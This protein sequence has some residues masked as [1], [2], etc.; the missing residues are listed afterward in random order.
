MP[1]SFDELLRSE[2]EH[3]ER[4]YFAFDKMRTEARESVHA[5][6]DYVRS[7]AYE[8]Q[9]AFMA[10]GDMSA[11]RNKRHKVEN[12]V[13]KLYR[14]PYFAH[15]ELREEEYGDI[16]HFYLSDSESLDEVVHIGRYGS[17]IPFKQDKDRPISMA[18]FHLYQSKNGDAMHY[19]GNDGSMIGFSPLLICDDEIE[20]RELLNV[21]QLFPEQELL[22]VNADE[23]LEQKLLENR[24]DP[25]LKNII[26][27]LQ[28]KQFQIIE[29]DVHI[30]FI[31]QGCAGSGKSQ[32]LLHRLFFLRDVLSQDGRDKVLLLT[33]TQ[34]FRNYSAELIKRYQ[35]S[36]IANCSISE[37]YQTLLNRYDNRF[38]NRQYQFELTEEYLPDAYLHVVYSED[39]LQLIEREI[40]KAIQSY[41]K[42]AC[43]ALGETLSTYIDAVYITSLITKLDKEIALFDERELVL[44]Q[45]PDYIDHRNRYEEVQKELESLQRVADRWTKE[46]E[47]LTQDEEKLS[48]AVLNFQ[49]VKKEVAQWKSQ[50]EKRIASAF[51]AVARFDKLLESD[52]RYEAPAR[53]MKNLYSL[54][55]LTTG[56]TYRDDEEYLQF[57]NEYYEQAEKELLELTK[58]QTP[59]RLS[60]RY[61]KRKEDIRH[62]LTDISVSIESLSLELA[63]NEEWLREKAAE[64][65]G[66]K[67]TRTLR[68]ADMERARYFLARIES[69]VFEREVWNAL[70][71]IKEEN[72]IQT[73]IIEEKKD[74][75]HH[76]TRILYKSDLL[77]YIKI[78]MRLLPNADLPEYSLLCID[79]GQDLHKADYDVLHQLYPNAV[80]NIFGDTEQV[81]HEDCG[82]S[83]W[84]GETGVKKMFNLETNYRN[85][86]GIV[87]FCNRRFGCEMKYLGKAQEN[88][89]PVV[90]QNLSSIKN[91][92]QDEN[93]VVILKDRK[94]FEMFVDIINYENRCEFLDT[95]A[96]STDGEKISCYSIF[97]AKG[98]EFSRV[99]VFASEMTINQRIVA[100]TRATEKLYYYE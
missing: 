7:G 64:F 49:D 36:D 10:Y 98:L 27:T 20:N 66:E 18:L 60:K 71:P 88:Q 46:L 92:L 21:M 13:Q 25:R 84:Q 8:D 87:E 56:D 74:G 61:A 32:C 33:P 77:F 97:A 34:L 96:A 9:D 23:L 38:R 43:E 54:K 19:R 79:E 45:D 65:E 12:L 86:A 42:A 50:R 69:T 57:L 51:R 90:L 62:R 31:V 73:L 59:E 16:E 37:L 41:T 81:L 80:F 68:R 67:S 95:N 83:N 40:E 28:Q 48:E 11:A 2:T 14:K 70:A 47:Q 75:R 29:T 58:T 26:A 30:S 52:G 63:Q 4:V 5:S 82:I 100:C 22:W 94:N 76:E 99:L 78:Y 24:S 93:I 15:I 55:D 6:E 3:K 85:A 1:T 89:M 72:N 91:A 39:T 17:L 35:L 53:F 44:Q